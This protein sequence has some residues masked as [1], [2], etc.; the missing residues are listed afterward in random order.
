M[1]DSLS[2]EYNTTR[3]LLT[4]PE[5]GRSVQKMVEYAL[6]I[7]DREQR[8]QVAKAIVNIM[9]QLNPLVK[10]QNDYKHKLWDHLHF[11]ADFKLDVDSP[12]TAPTALELAAKPE[13]VPYGDKNFRYGHYGRNIE[14]IIEKATELE[15]GPEKES[16]VKA[17]GNHLKKTYLTW[18]RDSVN[19][20]LIY[21]HLK[22]L[23]HGKLKLA[24]D[25]QL[26]HTNDLLARTAKKKKFTGRPKDNPGMKR[27]KKL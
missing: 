10:E 9:A 4:L 8:S 15:D 13:T 7:G 26:S 5:Y 21:E 23:S 14:K 2:L 24:D 17:I 20:E 25:T 22:E 11:I 19:D 16:Y 3:N 6:T 27:K 12:F 1:E 18:N